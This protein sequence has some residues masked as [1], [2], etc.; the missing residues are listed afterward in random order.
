MW[1]RVSLTG[2]ISCCWVRDLG[3]NSAYAKNQSVSW[4]DNKNNHHGTDAIDSNAIITIKKRQFI[5]VAV[6]SNTK[7][8]DYV[9]DPKIMIL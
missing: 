9:E 1:V 5:Y 8:N 2:K 4:H 7:D 3:S 6:S